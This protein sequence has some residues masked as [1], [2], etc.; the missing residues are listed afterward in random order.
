MLWPPFAQMIR[1]LLTWEYL[2]LLITICMPSAA[3][4]VEV[5]HGSFQ[6]WLIVECGRRGD[7]EKEVKTSKWKRRNRTGP[8]P[9]F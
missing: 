1:C 4:W 9:R 6:L 7:S 5:L 8:I 2:Y 3:A